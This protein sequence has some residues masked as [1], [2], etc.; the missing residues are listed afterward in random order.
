LAGKERNLFLAN[1]GLA[2]LKQYFG[3]LYATLAHTHSYLARVPLLMHANNGTVPAAS[4]LYLVPA[5]QG[6][7]SLN[8]VAL[9]FACTIKNL[10]VRSNFTQP[11]TGTMVVTV[12]KEVVDTALTLTI[13]ANAAAQTWSDAVHSVSFAAGERLGLKF[14]NNASGIS[15]S[16]TAVSVEL[17]ASVL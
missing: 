8:A 16:I 14:V 1:T 12:Q 11:S 5:L 6:F 17:Q 13:A 10:T 7:V 9:P 15:A 2:L 4:T 3:A